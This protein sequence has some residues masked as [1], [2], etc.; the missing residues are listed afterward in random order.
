M[1]DAKDIS[2]LR[3]VPEEHSVI[4]LFELGYSFSFSW[5]FQCE[6]VLDQF[7]IEV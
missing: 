2:E 3:A 6:D 5:A 1:E 4:Q 7:F